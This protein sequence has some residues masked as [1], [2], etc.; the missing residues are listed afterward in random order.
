[1]I[2]L[3]IAISFANF[4]QTNADST[5]TLK[6]ESKK[7]QLIIPADKYIYAENCCVDQ[8]YRDKIVSTTEPLENIVRVICNSGSSAISISDGVVSNVFHIADFKVVLIKH[9]KYYT[10]YSNLSDV[11]VKQGENVS[12]KQKLGL[13]NTD[14]NKTILRFEIWYNKNKVDPNDWISLN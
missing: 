8:N 7:G 13:I 5:E 10:V 4:G 2:I 3:I 12:E 14:D 6:F 1:M 9:G 11:S